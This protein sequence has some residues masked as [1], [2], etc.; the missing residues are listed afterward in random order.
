MV[1]DLKQRVGEGFGAVHVPPFLVIKVFVR[2]ERNVVGCDVGVYLK[3][4]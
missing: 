4:D 3:Q 1:R 2:E